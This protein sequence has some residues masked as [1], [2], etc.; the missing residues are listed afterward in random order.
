MAESGFSWILAAC[1]VYG[2]LHSVLA[3]NGTKR[4]AARIIGQA[5]YTRIY[6]LFFAVV[7]GIT[8]LPMLALPTLLPDREIYRITTPWV[9][10]TLLLQALA[11]AALLVGVMQTGGMRFVGIEQ[12]FDPDAASARDRLVVSGLYR[13]VRH[14]LYTASFIFL[15]LTPVMTWNL[16]ALIIGLSAY[17]LIGTIFEE[18][19]LVEQFGTDY[20]AYRKKTPRIVPGFG[21]KQ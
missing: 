10:L 19:K 1:A 18:Q 3:A 13:Y 17:M 16:L 6:R 11:A 7:A 2:V 5:A 14:P 4:W 15:W 8:A 20:E 12:L 21:G 9:Y